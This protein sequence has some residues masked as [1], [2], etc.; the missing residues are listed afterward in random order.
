M[1]IDIARFYRHYQFTRR[2]DG[3]QWSGGIASLCNGFDAGF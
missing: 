1:G 3:T 2:N